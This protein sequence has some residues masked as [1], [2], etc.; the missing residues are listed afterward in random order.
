M[1]SVST[2]T[3]V[4]LGILSGGVIIGG[5]AAFVVKATG[6]EYTS[7]PTDETRRYQGKTSRRHR[8]ETRR[9]IQSHMERSYPYGS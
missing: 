7:V 3:A 6:P 1:T 9:R 8:R 5:L 2:N 4:I